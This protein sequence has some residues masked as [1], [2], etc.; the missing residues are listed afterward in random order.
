MTGKAVLGF[1]YLEWCDY[2][3]FDVDNL[4]EGPSS[5]R[6]SLEVWAQANQGNHLQLQIMRGARGWGRLHQVLE[7]S[8]ARRLQLHF[9]PVPGKGLIQKQMYL[10]LP[11]APQGRASCLW[12]E[13]QY[14]VGTVAG[15]QRKFHI[16]P[17]FLPLCNGPGD[18]AS[19]SGDSPASQPALETLAP[20]QSQ[21]LKLQASQPLPLE[22]GP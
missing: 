2:G 3:T 17:R 21:A 20:G 10:S 11:T 12:V 8:E 14:A 7:S 15:G 6:L 13:C 5:Q 9:P 22:A 19:P 1:D 18:P 16:S 4:P